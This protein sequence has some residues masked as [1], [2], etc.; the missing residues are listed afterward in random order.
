MTEEYKYALKVLLRAVGVSAG[1]FVVF[2]IVCL[3]MINLS[4]G[5]E[6]LKASFEVVDKYKECDVVRYAPHQVA[7]YKY[8]LYCE[9]NK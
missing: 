4:T 5:D 7:E 6:P 9:K 3:V 1:V 2:S 8:F